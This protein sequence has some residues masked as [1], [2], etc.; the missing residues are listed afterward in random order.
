[1]KKKKKVKKEEKVV[2]TETKVRKA[3]KVYDLPGQKRDPPEEVWIMM[4]LHILSYIFRLCFV[5][6]LVIAFYIFVIFQRDPLRVF[7]E[8][9]HEQIPTS[10]MSQ[11]WWVLKGAILCWCFSFS[12]SKLLSSSR[13]VGKWISLVTRL[14]FL[15]RIPMRW[16]W[17]STQKLWS[18]SI[19][20]ALT[21][22]YE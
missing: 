21:F 10:E 5:M 4:H 9:L 3:K 19:D 1:M 12:I 7:Y 14:W 22:W 8:T 13:N 18:T 17:I 6:F 15:W 11:I 20:T 2:V 16:M